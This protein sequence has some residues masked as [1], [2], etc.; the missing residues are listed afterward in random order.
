[1]ISFNNVNYFIGGR[2][3]L[4]NVTFQIAPKQHVGLVGRNGTGKTTLF[5]LI[6]KILTPDD[7]TIN[8]AKDWKI[9]SVKQEMPDG[10]L[11][12]LEYLMN[13][14]TERI[15]LLKELDGLED[16]D[17]ICEIYDR[18]TQIDAYTAEARA[19]SLLDGLGFTEEEQYTSIKDLSGGYRMRVALAAMLYQEPDM[20]LLD[21]PTNHLDFET[22][23][24]LESFLRKYPKSFLLISHD[25]EFLNNTVNYILHLKNSKITRYTGNFD[26]FIDTYTLKQQ[27]IASSN[28]KLEKQRAHMMEFVN[29]FLYKATKARQAQSRLKA[30]A[31]LKFIPVEKDD[32]TIS[33]QFP[34]PDE[35]APPLLTFDKVFL[36][37]GDKTILKHVSG[38]I[39]P[40]DRICLVGA[41]G[42]GKS[43]FAKFLAREITPQKGEV[44]FSSKLKIGFYRQDQFDKLDTNYTAY[45]HVM[46]N[47]NTSNDLMIRSHLGR[48]GFEKEK[49]EQKVKNLSGGERAR[50]LFACLTAQKPNLLILDEPTN[51]L[52]MEMRESLICSIGTYKGAVILITHDRNL[53]SKVANTIWVVKNSKITEFDGDIKDY[54]QSLKS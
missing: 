51:H 23:K 21:E 35:L 32:P 3:L 16:A 52:D 29:R 6:E 26:T 53:L 14:D 44:F 54:E 15:A 49:S 22:T 25:R 31:K 28:A 30:I 37:Y 41:N 12:P 1:M 9:L 36:G 40:D 19:A 48:F 24:W 4:E 50:L 8:I 43:T 39:R 45:E 34:E 33:F 2:H 38:S 18:L 17:R 13:Q 5:K 47:L 11:C 7:G 10:D 42:N 20:M 46:H 27:N